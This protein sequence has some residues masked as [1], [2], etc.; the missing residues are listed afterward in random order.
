MNPKKL[1]NYEVE[2][3][4]DLIPEIEKMYNFTFEN[5]ELENV[6]NFK[7][8]AELIIEKIDLENVES[9]TTQQAFYKL[10]KS[11]SELGILEKNKLNTETKLKEIFPRKNRRQI[12]KSLEE[13]IGF[14][15]NIINPPLIL[16][17]SLLV[18]GIV[19]F[20]LLFIFLK[21]GI[22]GFGITI[23]GFYLSLK[24]GKEIQL[25]SLRELVAKITTENYLNLRTESNTIN[26][27]ELNKVI[28]E[29]VSEN[30]GIKKEK[31]ITSTF[32]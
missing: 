2:N 15:L 29:W 16:I 32:T 5:D 12:V 30:S 19:S 4:E 31:L 14:K 20:I 1:D 27:K 13:N 11:I 28:L 3:I 25:N 21:I 22:I 24:F 18:L 17:N 9:C 23:L 26:R 6:T 10:R 8:F 7:Q